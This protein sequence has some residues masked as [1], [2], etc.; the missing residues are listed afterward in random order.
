M[1]ILGGGGEVNADEPDNRGQTLLS[2]A[3]S[4]GR[5]EEV[6]YYS[7]VRWLIPTNRIISAKHGSRGPL[8]SDVSK[9]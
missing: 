3:T 7:D 9:L 5:E 8:G 2:H 4:P 6:Q 1:E